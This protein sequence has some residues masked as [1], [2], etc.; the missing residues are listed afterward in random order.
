MA[1]SEEKQISFHGI[2]TVSVDYK[3]VHIIRNVLSND[4]M[5]FFSK[6]GKYPN[7][8]PYAGTLPQM[9]RIINDAIKIGKGGEEQFIKTG[10]Y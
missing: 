10:T 6:E 2:H 5:L 3:G 4:W 1:K 8:S 7:Q 9:K